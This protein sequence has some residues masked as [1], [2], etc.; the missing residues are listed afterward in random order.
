MCLDLNGYPY[1]LYTDK[2]GNVV[3]AGCAHLESGERILLGINALIFSV[4]VLSFKVNLFGFYKWALNWLQ[5]L[6]C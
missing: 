6:E 3:P 4:L 2:S 1:P 5:V